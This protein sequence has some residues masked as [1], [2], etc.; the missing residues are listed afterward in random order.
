MKT[1]NCLRNAAEEYGVLLEDLY[2]PIEQ[3]PEVTLEVTKLLA[4]HH[5]LCIMESYK[6]KPKRLARKLGWSVKKLKSFLMA[7]KV[8]LKKIVYILY[9]LGEETMINS[10][11]FT[12]R[13]PSWMRNTPSPTLGI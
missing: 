12:V 9:A 7:D 3:S 10:R 8:T 13:S 1:P 2:H 11:K 6:V 4:V 5:I